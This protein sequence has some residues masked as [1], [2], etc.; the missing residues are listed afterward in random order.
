MQEGQLR[1]L[2]E[3]GD[4]KSVA[5][6]GVPMS[7]AWCLQFT[8]KNGQQLLLD[9]QRTAPRCFKTLDAAFSSALSLGFRQ[10]KVIAP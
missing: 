10:A 5:I 2:F 7:S 6:V 8:R 9:S 1:V 3:C 4:L